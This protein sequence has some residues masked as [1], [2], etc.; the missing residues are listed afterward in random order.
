MN[1]AGF[2]VLLAMI[3]PTLAA[4]ASATP[5]Q[6]PPLQLRAIRHNEQGVAAEQRRDIARAMAEF[7][8]AYRLH[9]AIEN[10]P[11]MITALLNTARLHRLHGEPAKAAD[12]VE[13]ALPLAAATPDLA[14]EIYFEKAKLL[15]SLGK[16]ADAISWVDRAIAAAPRGSRGRMVN[17]LAEIRLRESAWPAA[18]A[19]AEEGLKLTRET[20]DQREEANALR[21]LAETA[22]GERQFTEA[23]NRFTEALT[24]DK[25]LGLPAKIASDLRGLAQTAAGGGDSKA[26]LA[27]WERAADVSLASGDLKQTTA[28]LRQL[29]EQAAQC[30]DFDLEAKARAR[31]TK[32]PPPVAA[33]Q[34]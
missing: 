2:Y 23:G 24:I 21:L 9:S 26:A 28:N 12:A 10:Q 34:R 30:G 29:A 6:L 31:L 4:C 20:A 3:L 27:F 17:L 15:L 7:A 18:R 11:G 8:A 5:R 33:E 19:L 32:I 22:L 16:R 25:G 1:K 14:A 13:L